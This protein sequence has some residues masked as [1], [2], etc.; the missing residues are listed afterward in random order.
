VGAYIA[1]RSLSG[2]VAPPNNIASIAG[3][4]LERIFQTL[5]N[6]IDHHLPPY[7]AVGE[8]EEYSSYS[9]KE[10][11]RTKRCTRVAPAP[12]AWREPPSSIRRRARGS[13]HKEIYVTF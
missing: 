11:T 8:E 2:T 4:A 13:I 5:R 3:G 9:K 10:K 7:T 6:E 1:L 12:E